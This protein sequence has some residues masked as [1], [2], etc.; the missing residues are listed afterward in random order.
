MTASGPARVSG[1]SLEGP[2]LLRFLAKIDQRGPDECWPWTAATDRHGYGVYFVPTPDGPKRGQ[3][4]KAHRLSLELKL[5]RALDRSEEA[6]HKC[7]HPPCCNPRHLEPGSHADNMND[8][9]QRGRW[10]A[11]R[12]IGM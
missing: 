3:T 1:A 2:I 11:G 10:N 5:G 12:R 6:R 4:H 8:A 9:I 7:D